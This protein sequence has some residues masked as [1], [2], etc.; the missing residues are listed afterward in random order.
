MVPATVA[1]AADSAELRLL[2]SPFIR[3]RISWVAAVNCG[4]YEGRVVNG[5]LGGALAGV[6]VGAGLS[7]GDGAAVV[8][9]DAL[10]APG[11]APRSADDPSDMVL[12]ERKGVSWRPLQG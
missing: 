5:E 4:A 12:G 7:T 11:T 10:S 3:F 9:F 6:P 2:V 8:P 1:E